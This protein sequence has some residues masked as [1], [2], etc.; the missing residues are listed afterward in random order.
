MKPLFGA[1]QEAL[2]SESTQDFK[3]PP[4]SVAGTIF[5][6][7]DVEIFKNLFTLPTNKHMLEYIASA[8]TDS[9]WLAN[10]S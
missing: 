7:D 9:D 6:L 3:G 5:W 4:M 2:V 8:F 10:R 1:I